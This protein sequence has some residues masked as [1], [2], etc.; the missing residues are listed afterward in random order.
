[1]LEALFEEI[2]QKKTASISF[3]FFALT[4]IIG[5]DRTLPRNK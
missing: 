2:L 3:S 5:G 4:L 1:M